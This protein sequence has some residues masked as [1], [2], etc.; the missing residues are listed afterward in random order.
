M[1]D[2]TPDI[3][4]L[5]HQ[6]RRRWKRVNW[7][8]PAYRAHLGDQ[9]PPFPTDLYLG[10]A[11][12]HRLSSAWSTIETELAPDARRIVSRLPTADTTADDLWAEAV[13]RLMSEDPG[14][15]RLPGGQYPARIIRYRGLVRLLNYLVTISRRLAIQ[16]DRRRRHASV[17]LH[18][19]EVGADRL[20]HANHAQTPDEQ[21]LQDEAVERAAVALRAAWRAL[22][23]DQQFLLMMVYRHGVSQRRAGDWLG[24]SESKTSRQIND[25][26]GQ[27]GE[28]LRRAAGSSWNPSLAAAWGGLWADCWEEAPA[29]R[30]ATRP[31]HAEDAKA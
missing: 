14:A 30:S 18:G 3:H 22:A 13:L 17:A 21:T 4:G 31:V 24:W 25:A 29:F 27:L 6:A 2:R 8:L 12:G 5:Y 20:R 11:A 1:S 9:V 19:G 7:P 23:A 26:I 16:R 10:G 15:A 28:A